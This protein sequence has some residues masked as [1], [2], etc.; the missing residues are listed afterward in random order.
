MT[1]GDKTNALSLRERFKDNSFIYTLKAYGYD[2]VYV[3]FKNNR[4]YIE[5]NARVLEAVIKKVNQVKTGTNKISIIGFSM[6]GLVTRW[7]LKDMEDRGVTHNVGKYFSYDA[8]HQGANVPLGCQYLFKE[9]IRDLPYLKWFNAGSTSDKP[10]LRDLDNAFE[11]A[12][13]RQMLVT[14]GTYNNFGFNYNPNLITLN[15]LRAAF[16][17]RLVSKGYPQQTTNYGIAFGE[18]NNTTG[19]KN[20]GNGKQFGNFNAGDQILNA[21]E[22]LALVNFTSQVWAVPENNNTSAICKYKFAGLTW[23]KIFGVIPSFTFTLRIRNF[24][25]NGQYPYDD[26]PGGYDVTQGQ[27]AFSIVHAAGSATTYNHDGHDFVPVTSSLDLQNQS[28][29]STNKWQSANMFFNIDSYI[30]NR[31]S[32]SGGTLSTPSLSPFSQVVTGSSLYNFT[33]NFNQ[34]HNGNIQYQIAGFMLNKI[35]GFDPSP[36]CQTDGFCNITTTISGPAIVCSTGV[37]IANNLPNGLNLNWSSMYGSFNITSGQGTNQ[38]TITKAFDKADTLILSITNSC[39]TTRQIKFG[40]QVGVVTAPLIQPTNYDAQ[41]GTFME[42]YCTEPTG[43]TGYVWNLNFGQVIQDQ[44][45]PYTNYFYIAPLVNN[46]QQG[47]RYFNYLTVQAKNACGLSASS[48]TKSFT[49]GPVPS[50]CG[51]GG[52]LLL[53]V[54]PNPSSSSVKVSSGKSSF[55]QLRVIDKTGIVRKQFNYPSGTNIATINISDLPA[56]VYNILAFDGINWTAVKFL[57]N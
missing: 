34:Y 1:P 17:Q 43:A 46:P 50:T 26:A 11:S 24:N 13:G 51:G 29:S 20:A 39:G 2:L 55:V 15:D 35:L 47:M 30:Q 45:G 25:Y 38:V 14:K 44:D 48:A 21:S 54:S 4:D 16:A 33:S 6:G 37:Y 42:A 57:K 49:V 9:L 36:N 41:C 27:F 5:N 40:I 10:G 7:C 22:I 18:G 32:F 19:T 31:T 56:D 23:R 52:P 8:P 28:Y 12:A 53:V 3:D